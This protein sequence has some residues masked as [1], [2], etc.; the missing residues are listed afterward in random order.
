MNEVIVSRGRKPFAAVSISNFISKHPETSE[1]SIND[2]YALYQEENEKSDSKSVAFNTFKVNFYSKTFKNNIIPSIYDIKPVVK[3]SN[4]LSLKDQFKR[5]ETY[6]QIV[7][8]GNM[9]ALYIGGDS[10]I[11]KTDTV[12]KALVALNAPYIVYQGGS[13]GVSELVQILYN[14]REEKIIVFDDFDSI[15]KNKACRDVLKCAMNDTKKRII[16]WVDNTKRNKKNSVPSQFTFTSGIIIISNVTRIDKAIR[17]RMQ[18]SIVHATKEESLEWVKDHFDT[19]V[20]GVPMK[21]KIEV[22]EF[23]KL[24][25]NKF[26]M[27]NYRIFKNVLMDRLIDY[28]MNNNDGIWKKIA[29]SSANF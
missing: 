2:S 17:S 18:V 3:S 13:K 11:G 20:E 6:V 4:I 26:K 16:S 22:Y 15:F 8:E 23:I 27:M 29:L 25:I 7:V 28:K 19:F 5:V 9:S 21:L 10:S 12:D 14:N 24:N 1:M